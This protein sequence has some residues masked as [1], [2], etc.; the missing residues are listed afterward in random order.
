[1]IVRVSPSSGHHLYLV[2]RQNIRVV[3]QLHNISHPAPYKSN[4]FSARIKPSQCC[5][6]GSLLRPLQSD[7]K[8]PRD[9]RHRT[10]T[11]QIAS[12]TDGWHWSMGGGK[13]WSILHQPARCQINFP[14][15]GTRSSRVIADGAL[16]PNKMQ[17]A[18][19]GWIKSSVAT[20]CPVI[21]LWPVFLAPWSLR[22][23]GLCAHISY[24]ASIIFLIAAVTHLASL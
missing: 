11:R 6:P 23:P 19:C 2:C 15:G 1:M 18:R 20:D 22:G 24:R 5:T 4:I 7:Y 12:Q 8:Y 13:T 16:P 17:S 9:S 21:S 14:E 10:Q 3:R